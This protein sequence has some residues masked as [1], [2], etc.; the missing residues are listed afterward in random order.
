MTITL[1]PTVE[2]KLRAAAQARGVPAE[3]YAR[4]LLEEHFSWPAE[5]PRRENNSS[6]ALQPLWVLEGSVPHL[7][8]DELY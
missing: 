1:A 2:Q 7:S 5:P 3:D 8:K 4:E 6:A